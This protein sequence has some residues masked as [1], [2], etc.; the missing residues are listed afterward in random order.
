MARDGSL[1]YPPEARQAAPAASWWSRWRT[2]LGNRRQHRATARAL[3]A[4]VV[5]QAR[6]P[7]FY[8]EWGVPDSRDGRLEL[9]TAHAILVMRRLQSEGAAGAALAQALF[10]VLFA[11]LDRHLREW[12]VA[13][14]SVGK[15]MKKLAQS[16]YGRASALDALLDGRDPPALD[17]VLRRNVY[18]E[19]RSPSDLAVRRLGAYLCAQARFLTSQDGAD[20]LAGRLCFAAPEQLLDDKS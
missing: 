13:D 4:A 15:E 8:A 19:A 7:V 2:A 10:D 5:Q 12:G 9:V 14:L 1:A 6:L 20:L 18:T 3:Y 16:F 17:A 11:D